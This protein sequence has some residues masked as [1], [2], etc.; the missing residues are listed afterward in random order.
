MDLCGGEI[1]SERLEADSTYGS[2]A[3]SDSS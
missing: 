1:E 2:L 3:I